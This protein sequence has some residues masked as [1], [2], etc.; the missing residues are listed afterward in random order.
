MLSGI[1]FVLFL[2]YLA[3][4]ELL[5]FDD[6]EQNAVGGPAQGWGSPWA[7]L[8]SDT[9]WKVVMDGSTK[10]YRHWS[11]DST[12]PADVFAVD[13]DP[14]PVAFT[15]QVKIKVTDFFPNSSPYFFDPKVG[16][17]YGGNIA[18]YYSPY[19]D[20]KKGLFLSDAL[21]NTPYFA[22][23]PYDLEINNWYYFKIGQSDTV[24]QR[25]PQ[26]YFKVWP[27]EEEEPVNW[28][29]YPGPDG[30]YLTWAYLN[31]CV[32]LSESVCHHYLGFC[33][34]AT[35]AN[36]DEVKVFSEL[37]VVKVDDDDQV[38]MPKAFQLYQNYPNPF[39]STTVIG[40][41]VPEI[42]SEERLRRTTL[43]IY[44]ILGQEVKTLV[45]NIQDPGGY[46]A[47]WDGRDDV[48][49]AVASGIYFCR[50][51]TGANLYDMRKLVLLK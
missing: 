26:I 8:Y 31:L 14:P 2:P 33:A 28:M 50:L 48:G 45:D 22:Y 7:S 1:L 18:C 23:L 19:L 15:A 30:H 43:R 20:H 40:Y 38:V 46:Q 35:Y 49:R 42:D 27:E 47:A 51:T 21:I 11:G 16:F 13:Y 36:F 5:W 9:T 3:Q 39:N 17:C 4:A 32:Y 24:N 12:L 25:P 37:D 44:N 34:Y 29:I 6:F 41:S 10:V